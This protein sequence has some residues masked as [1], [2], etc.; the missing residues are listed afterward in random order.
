MYMAVTVLWLVCDTVKY[1]LS[2]QA[3]Y[4]ALGRANLITGFWSK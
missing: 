4:K 2:V 1:K 3:N